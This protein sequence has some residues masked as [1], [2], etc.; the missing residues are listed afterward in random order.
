MMAGDKE[1]FLHSSAFRSSNG[2]GVRFHPRTSDWFE[3]HKRNCE[4]IVVL[5]EGKY[6]LECKGEQ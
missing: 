4:A 3:H 1:H 6:V 5:W 2:D